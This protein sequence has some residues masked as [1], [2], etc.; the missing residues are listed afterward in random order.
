MIESYCKMTTEIKSK[1]NFEA[2]LIG[3]M[4]V[5]EYYEFV[6]K[7]NY[8][9]L[10][11]MYATNAEFIWNGNCLTNQENI[12]DFYRQMPQSKFQILSMDAQPTFKANCYPNS[13]SYMVSV[14]GNVTY[15]LLEEKHHFTHYFFLSQVDGTI[16]IVKEVY[17]TQA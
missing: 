9:K 7:N 2:K 16:K 13:I 10:K 17:R 1:C 3:D 12:V 8:N 11:Y 14:S 15:T 5:Q 6:E 4:L